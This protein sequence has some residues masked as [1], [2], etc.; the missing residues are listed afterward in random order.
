MKRFWPSS[1]VLLLAVSAH[2]QMLELP[3]TLDPRDL[4]GPLYTDALGDRLAGEIDAIE[5]ELGSRG[6]EVPVEMEAIL[7]WRFAAQSTMEAGLRR[8][9]EDP[10]VLLHALRI[11]RLRH[12]FDAAVRAGKFSEAVLLRFVDAWRMASGGFLNATR[13]DVDAA[14]GRIFSALGE[15]SLHRPWPAVRRARANERMSFV[16]GLA[17]A[18]GWLADSATDPALADR[19]RPLVDVARR[20]ASFEEFRGAAERTVDLVGAAIRIDAEFADVRWAPEEWRQTWHARLC[21]G[22]DL[23]TRPTTRPAGEA[24]I[25]HLESVVRVLHAAGEIAANQSRREPLLDILAA[26]DQL[27]A[28]GEPAETTVD[29]TLAPPDD[30]LLARLLLLLE[31]MLEFRAA[32]RP[33]LSREF[34]RTRARLVN[35]YESAELA[36]LSEIPRVAGDRAA[37]LD[38]AFQSLVATHV[39]ALDWIRRIDSVPA[40]LATIEAFTPAARLDVERTLRGWFKS[41]LDPLQRAEA[42]RAIEQVAD[43]MARYRVLPLEAELRSGAADLTALTAGRVGE[44]L[45]AID[46]ARRTWVERVASREGPV[47]AELDVLARL[48]AV[49]HDVRTLVN[50]EDVGERLNEWGAWDVPPMLT[51]RLMSDLPGRIK[52]AVASAGAGNQ[53][54][55]RRQVQAL[56]RDLPYGRLAGA[57]IR[58]SPIANAGDALTAGIVA[59]STPPRGAVW[60]IGTREEV[61]ALC[62]WTVEL[63]AARRNDRADDIERIESYITH[64]CETIAAAIE[65]A[66]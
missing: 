17:A 4:A 8:G 14:I 32:D 63:D 51:N 52:L 24:W 30:A 39:E 19:V 10:V 31:R 38:P 9:R 62:R 29:V 26:V 41:L 55:L 40:W 13:T 34:L 49:M 43:A 12:D 60:L 23:Y 36:L 5:T 6:G 33:D 7:A 44:L 50:A 2:A 35:A 46:A 66:G 11:A 61:A 54:D 57:Y 45:E 37:M 53:R 21:K 59:L 15:T 58:Q 22:L 18:D 64:L 16:D 25:A 27:P 65:R 47:A 42:S 56:E 28:R 3:Q 48:M 20:G 1:I